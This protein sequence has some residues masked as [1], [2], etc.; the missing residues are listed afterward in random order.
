[1][2]YLELIHDD[3]ASIEQLMREESLN[4]NKDLEAAFQLLLTAGGKRIR[5][6]LSVLCGR[7]FGAGLDR[8]HRLAAAIELLH[9]ATLVH[10][11]LID[12]SLLRRGMP[13]LNARWGP[14]A[15]V[16]TGDFVFARAAHMA[17]STESVELMKLFSK[18]LSII[19]DGEIDQL[20]SNR[21]KADRSNYIKRIY[22][23]TA[24]LF[25]T[26]CES[27]SILSDSSNS[28]QRSDIRAYGYYVG[29]AFQIVDDILD[30]TSDTNSLGK[31]VGSDFRAGII[32]LP[33]ILY[34]ELHPDT[35]IA[36]NLLSGRCLNQPEI[37]DDVI[38]TIRNS[39]A[40]KRSYNEA[41]A[42]AEKAIS[43][44]SDMP[45]C[46]EKDA[47]ISIASNYVRRES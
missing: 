31:P 36:V 15:T 2:K 14:G 41:D 30:F 43:K 44:L 40:I 20:F 19:V 24:S 42:F 28:R 12:G 35:Q 25:E 37:V 4:F 5:P 9:T 1:M 45:D 27:A 7:M 21:C 33:A 46:R 22:S 32:T 29:I 38:D 8:V 3:I 13:T 11:D 16:L 23:K 18:T 47:L 6:T 34:A 39:D 10:D 26:A 17:A